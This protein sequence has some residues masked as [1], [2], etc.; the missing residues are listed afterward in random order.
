MTFSGVDSVGFCRPRGRPP[1]L[2]GRVLVLGGRVLVLGGPAGH[3]APVGAGARGGAPRAPPVEAEAEVEV[4]VLASSISRRRDE[5]SCV[6]GI[7]E[8]F[9]MLLSATSRF[10]E[11]NLQREEYVCLKAMILLNSN[12][13][14]S[15]PET[16][17]E[18]ESRNRLLRLLDLVIDGL[19]RGEDEFPGVVHGPPHE[20]QHQNLQP[21]T[22][23]Q[24]DLMSGGSAS[25]MR[26][27]KCWGL[28]GAGQWRGRPPSRPSGGRK[29][30]SG[31]S[32][33]RGPSRG[34]SSLTR[35]PARPGPPAPGSLAPPPSPRRWRAPR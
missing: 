12:M 21:A 8:I 20:A 31:P 27:M 10:R 22:L 6:E 14:T 32:R 25:M 5:G 29:D 7:T 19:V 30:S 9:D 11:L 13:C 23:Q 1:V 16:A 15:V 4:E 28:M 34:T 35:P 3:G 17:E 24:A 33:C 26:W 2:G 18:L